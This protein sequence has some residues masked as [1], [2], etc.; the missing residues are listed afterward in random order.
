MDLAMLTLL[1][2]R[3][4]EKDDWE[5]LLEQADGRLRFKF[6]R[7]RPGSSTAVLVASLNTVQER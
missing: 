7:T 2:S 3:E 1:N 4:R 5:H 6:M